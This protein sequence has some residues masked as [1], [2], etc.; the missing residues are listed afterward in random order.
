MAYASASN[1]LTTKTALQTTQDLTAGR[2]LASAGI[3][4]LTASATAVAADCSLG[5]VFLLSGLGTLAGTPTLT[6]SNMV[7]GQWVTLIVQASGTQQTITFAGTTSTGT[8]ATGT[9]AA[10]TFVVNFIGRTTS[11]LAQVGAIGAAQA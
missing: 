4:T 8:L 3:V 11:A 2:V 9:D 6:F 5:N 7:P 1:Q 10:K